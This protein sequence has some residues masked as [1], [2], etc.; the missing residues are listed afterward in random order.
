MARKSNDLNISTSNIDR[1]V[2]GYLC[3]VQHPK[4]VLFGLVHCY[5]VEKLEAA[6]RRGF[7]GALISI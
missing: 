3:S 2:G 1:F 5:I 7:I 6:K 4:F